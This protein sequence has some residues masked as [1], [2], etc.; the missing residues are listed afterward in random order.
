MTQTLAT[1]K[2]TAHGWSFQMYD[3]RELSRVVRRG[4]LHEKQ[5]LEHL[6]TRNLRGGLA[7]D[8]GAHVGVHTMWLAAVCR[9]QVVAFEPIYHEALQRNVVLNWLDGGVQIE[10]AALGAEP[11]WARRLDN[12]VLDPVHLAPQG[13]PTG[14]QYAI[15]KLDDYELAP[16]IIKIDVNGMETQV[17]QG[18]ERTIRTHRPTV[19]VDVDDRREDAIR[20]VLEGWGYTWQTT[21]VDRH[22]AVSEW[23]PNDS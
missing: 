20:W 18:G 8:V 17:L 12:D 19:Y 22:S 6:Y 23:L 10:A 15:H 9:T 7:V 21:F 2:F 5:L 11:G 13:V 14:I 16:T 3:D 4:E 1:R